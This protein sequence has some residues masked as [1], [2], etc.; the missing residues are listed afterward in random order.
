MKDFKVPIQSLIDHIKTA[1][2]VDPW[3]KEMAEELLKELEVRCKDCLFGRPAKDESGNDAIRCFGDIH[4][5][6]WFCADAV[7]K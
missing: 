1:C 4:E 7:R 3:A 5:M 2:D 6:E